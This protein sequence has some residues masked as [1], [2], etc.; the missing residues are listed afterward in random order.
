[1]RRLKDE[2]LSHD[3]LFHTLLGVFEVHTGVYDGSKD[4]LQKSRDLRQTGP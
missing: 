1:V 2:P 3:N 4:I